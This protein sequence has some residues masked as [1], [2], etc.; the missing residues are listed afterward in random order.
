VEKLE[1]CEGVS[2][3]LKGRRQLLGKTAL[4][5][6]GAAPPSVYGQQPRESQKF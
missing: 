1:R 5:R 6:R 3:D 2:L 4:E